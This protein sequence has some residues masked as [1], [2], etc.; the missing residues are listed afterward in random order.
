MYFVAWL[1]FPKTFSWPQPTNHDMKWSEYDESLVRRSEIL[2]GFDVIDNLDKEL[3]DMNK[4]KI[5]KRTI[6]LS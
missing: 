3:K 2:L 4:G 6:S 5:G 1:S